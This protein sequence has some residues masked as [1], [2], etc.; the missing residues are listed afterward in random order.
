VWLNAPPAAL[1]AINRKAAWPRARVGAG[2]WASAA[3]AATVTQRKR[4]G[5]ACATMGTHDAMDTLPLR[6][7]TPPPG[8]TASLRLFIALWPPPA[9]AG[10]LS[11]RADRCLAD[12]PAR[13]EPPGRLHL[14]LHF[15][16]AV[17]RSR[18]PALQAALCRPFAPFELCFDVCTRWPS[19][20]VVAEPLSPPPGLLALHAALAQALAAL[21]QHTDLRTF[22]PHVTLARRHAGPWPDT[23]D[24]AA[25]LRWRVRRYVL[26]AS[27]PGP[28]ARYRVLM[29]CGA[30]LG[31]ASRNVAQPQH[32][33]A[34]AGVSLQAGHEG[35]E[36]RG[37]RDAKTRCG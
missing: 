19:G 22:R 36:S 12:A 24:A 23:Q 37:E 29:S 5:T 9:L 11:A 3:R 33:A 20:V 15:L 21:G 1:R 13:R 16:G 17:P 28:P 31:A 26:A 7:A 18:L 10:A 35:K 32:P 34:A 8:A 14:T 30:Q 27:V 6:D 2:V 4:G 25:P